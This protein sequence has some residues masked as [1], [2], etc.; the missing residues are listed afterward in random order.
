MKNK[1]FEECFL[2]YKSLIIKIV[3]DKTGDYQAAQEI[4]QKVFISFYTSMDRV[5][6]ELE[7]AWL[8]RCTQNAVIDYVRK[9]QT[10]KEVLTD[11][12]VT[13]AGNA[14]MERSIDLYQKKLNDRELAGRILREVRAVNEQ[15]YEVLMLCCVDGMSYAEAAKELNIPE[16]VLRARMYRAR[17][18]IK[19]K[20]GDEYKKRN[21]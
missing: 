5:S 14:L 7:K 15:W 11:T 4:C 12:G 16:A 6:A 10:K 3:L 21:A 17:L 1:R 8:I 18:Y 19:E 13:E 2:K 9:V 20:F